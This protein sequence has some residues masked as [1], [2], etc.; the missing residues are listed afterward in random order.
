MESNDLCILFDYQ[1]YEFH[2]KVVEIIPV[3]KSCF[4]E[5]YVPCLFESEIRM[6]IF[7]KSMD[8]FKNNGYVVKGDLTT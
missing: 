4:S 3:G 5:T 2:P 7:I 6:Y 8:S 1:N